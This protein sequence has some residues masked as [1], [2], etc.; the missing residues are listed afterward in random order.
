MELLYNIDFEVAAIFYML[1]VNVFLRLKYSAKT[2]VNQEF[3]KM[4]GYL[5]IAVVLDVA[6]AIT[7]SYGKVIPGWFN[8]LFNVLYTAVDVVLGYQFMRYVSAY[9]YRERSAKPFRINRVIYFIC[10]LNLIINIFTGHVFYFDEQGVYVHGPLYMLVYIV[11]YYYILCSAVI[12]FRHYKEFEVKQRRSIIAFLVF[13][14]AGPVA[15]MLWFPDVLLSVFTMTL[16]LLM[17]MF[18]LETP[19]YQLLMETMGELETL[20]KNLQVE[21]ERQTAKADWLA[22]QSMKTLAFTIDAKDKYTNGHSMRV[23]EYARELIRRS[24]GTNKEQE[25]IYYI[26]LLHDL[27]KIGVPDHIINK[28]SK[29]TDEE[30]EVIKSHPVIGSKILKEI[31][32]EIPGIDTGARWHHERYDGKGYPDGLMGEQIPLEARVIGVADAYDAMTSNRSY[33]RELSQEY[34]KGEFEK[35]KGIQFDPY[36][37]ELMIQMIDEDVDFDMREK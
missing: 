27:G 36:F 24:G 3:R 12:L 13:G 6:T 20:Q 5:L 14:L 9:V 18:T 32:K 28:P 16:G 30:Y 33:R 1:I 21:V 23:A 31:S 34:V 22:L 37:A 2:H 10:L 7:I 29:L 8:M 19:D 25:N 11:P 4:A 35:G 15:Q 17:I 26:G